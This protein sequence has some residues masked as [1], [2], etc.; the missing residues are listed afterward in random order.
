MESLRYC[1]TISACDARKFQVLMQPF[2]DP[3]FVGDS[4][5]CMT[6]DTSSLS[7]QTESNKKR[8][9]S[10]HDGIFVDMLEQ[11]NPMLNELREASEDRKTPAAD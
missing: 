6:E 1:C 9:Q 7:Q 5:A 4:V 10:L 3:A 8:Q 11:G 2:L